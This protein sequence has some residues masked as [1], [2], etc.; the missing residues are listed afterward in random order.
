MLNAGNRNETI[1]KPLFILA[2]LLL[3]KLLHSQNIVIQDTSLKVSRGSFILLKDYKS[4][5]SNDTIIKIHSTLIPA[6]FSRKE[7]T[8]TFYDSL[9]SKASKTYFTKALF[10]L[11]IVLPDTVN[12]K[13]IISQSDENFKEYKGVKIRNINIQRLNV[14]G[15][16]ISNPGYYNPHGVEKI[17]N[18]THV[19]TNENIIKKNLLFAEGDT[20]SPLELT[21]NE[22]LLRQLPYIDDARIIVVPVSGEEADILVITKDV[23]SLGGDFTYRGKNKGSIW[24]Y[25]KNI[26]GMGHDFEIEIPYS[27]IN[28]DSPGIGLD[29]N[30]NNISKT[31]VNL[32]LNYYNGLGKKTYGFS[33]SRSLI[34][35]ETK[36]A[37]GIS[38]SEMF[39]SEDLDTL[40]EPQP[41]KWNFQDYWLLRSFLINRESVTRII[42]GL[43]YINNNV[44]EKP[45]TIPNTYY[46]LQKYSLYLGSVTYSRQKYYKTNL[47]YS[48]GRAE[49]IPYGGLIRFTGGIEINELNKR[50]YLGTDAAFGRS[51]SGLGYFYGSAG[52]GT[53]I[54]D[55]H[56]EQGV[57]SLKLKYFS[58]LVSA[59]KLMIRN[60]VNIDYTRGFD[61][62]S[63]EYLSVIK[64]N[65][66]AGFANDSLRG[67]QRVTVSLESVVFNPVNVIGFRFAFFG[68]ADMAFLAGTNE[69]ISKGSILSGIGLGIRIRNDN[70]VFSTFQI[71]LGFFPDPPM[72]SRIKYLSAS[73]EQ[74][75]RPTNFDPGPPAPIPYR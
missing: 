23:Y 58:N 1:I 59:G 72:Y 55:N 12:R 22:R 15:A 42:G 64:A 75:L 40:P 34:S 43:R 48:Y 21:D 36:Y 70:L 53:F 5:I 50:T 4:F 17:L 32:N 18:S 67:A 47:I 26:F 35:S 24:L 44:F 52:F 56:T 31:F 7:K 28:K 9:K 13:K 66:F 3:S 71:R 8:I 60:F 37:G 10:D 62:Y 30:I 39:T 65:G 54:K 63:D 38:V 16:N 69:V 41:L 61:R 20:I 11:V 49:D 45:V 14:F 2:L 29:Y 27:S 46:A 25:E 74:L 51:S 6:H 68:F 19:N 57:F 73:G 33:L